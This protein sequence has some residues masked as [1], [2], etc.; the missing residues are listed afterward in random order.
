[1][2]FAR[3]ILPIVS[4]L[5]LLGGANLLA[6]DKAFYEKKFVWDKERT[7]LSADFSK[8]KK[9]EL[10]DFKQVF[11]F[12][13]VHQDTTG[14]C[15]AFST[16]SFLE[17]EIYRLHQKKIKLSEMFV[18][19]WEYV[20]KARRFVRE[21]GNSAL[22]EGSESNSATARIKQYGI[23]PYEAYSGLLPG[24]TRYNHREM[25]REMDD[26]LHFIKDKGYWDE[27]IVLT[28][29][30]QILNKYMGEPPAKFTYQ[31]ETYTPIEFRDQVCGL[32]PDDYVEFMSTLKDTFYIKA[33]YKVPDNWWHSKDYHNIPLKVFYNAIKR[34]IKNGC[35]YR[36]S[37]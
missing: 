33:E 17:S 27:Q 2:N 24:Q 16:I 14:T 36:Y 22:G 4:L 13:P 25:F 18:V 3:R 15:W 6:Q 11:H 30:K 32:N 28:T 31:G 37:L 26:Y 9:P 5:L 29:I 8:V 1:M 35:G 10:K 23:V 21:K 34:S 12:A 7:I 20:E 19:Y